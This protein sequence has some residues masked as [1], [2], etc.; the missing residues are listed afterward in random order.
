VLLGNGFKFFVEEVKKGNK[1]LKD[2]VGGGMCFFFFFF[3]FLKKNGCQVSTAL[4]S[5]RL[6]ALVLSMVCEYC[7]CT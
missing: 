7:T 3:F 4:G 6:N 5:E 1:F 2:S